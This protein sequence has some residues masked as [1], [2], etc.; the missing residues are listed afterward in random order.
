MENIIVVAGGTGRLG[1]KIIT[2][3]LA[4]HAIVHAIVR[5]GTD[6]KKIAQLETLGAKVIIVDMTSRQQVSSACMHASCVVSALSGLRDVIIGVQR[7]LLDAAILAGVPRFIPSDYC[8]DF[9][10]LAPGQNRNLDLRRE[11]HQYLKQVPINVTTIFNGAFMDLLSGQMPLILTSF[12]RILYWG[13]ASQEMDFTTMN[14]V[15]SYTAAVAIDADA[16]RFLN[17]AGDRVNVLD[18]QNVIHELSQH[19]FKLFRAGS[20]DRLNRLI[21]ITKFL[22]PGKKDLYPAWQGMQYMRDMM[23]GKDVLQPLDNDRYPGIEWTR[24]QQF[25]TDHFNDKR[26]RN[27]K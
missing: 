16:P 23:E 9:R 17:I 21:T 11:F 26:A 7:V 24:I 22:F 4:R 14:N 6:S 25:L 27:L 19:P 1:G 2:N 3:L 8:L 20:I 18:V 13:N 10:N 12:K 5:T 15:A